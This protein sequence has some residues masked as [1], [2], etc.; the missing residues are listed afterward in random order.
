MLK[1]MCNKAGISGNYTNHSSCAFGATKL[2]QAGVSEKLIQQ[3]TGH[4][5]IEAL[6][7]YEWTSSTQL[8][9]VSNVMC[10][11]S[12]SSASNDVTKSCGPA[13]EKDSQQ[14][15]QPQFVFNGCT[16][17]GC[18]VASTGS[19]MKYCK[20]KAFQEEVDVSETLNF[21]GISYSD[22]FDE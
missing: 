7:Q 5:S 15:L 12:K 16:F 13:K 2:F 6:R 19:G 1:Q 22:I 9:D 10:N 14:L 21:K 11:M 3:R 8:L 18:A 17:N 4:R 20:E